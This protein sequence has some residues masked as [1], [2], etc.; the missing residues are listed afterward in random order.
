MVRQEV[1]WKVVGWVDEKEEKMVVEKA[2]H[3]VE[4][5]V[6][7]RAIVTVEQLGPWTGENMVVKKEY[8][9]DTLRDGWTAV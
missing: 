3:W 6:G 2:D 5:K 7:L 8:L 9:M 4:R 1:D